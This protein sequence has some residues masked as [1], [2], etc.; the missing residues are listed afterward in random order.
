[1]FVNAA[2]SANRQTFITP[3]DNLCL[4][5]SVTCMFFLDFERELEY[6]ERTL[7]CRHQGHEN[8]TQK[9]PSDGVK[10]LHHLVAPTLVKF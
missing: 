10:P 4:P 7:A 3:V 6:V 9:G 5:L 2:R 1:M 8:S